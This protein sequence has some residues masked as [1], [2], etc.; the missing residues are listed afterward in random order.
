MQEGNNVDGYGIFKMTHHPEESWRFISFLCSQSSQSYWNKSIG[1]IPTN[2]ESMKEEW[3]QELPHMQLAEKILSSPKL[4]FYEPPMYLP[5][6]RAILDLGNPGI[7]SVMTGEKSVE[8]FLDEWAGAFE[9]SKKNYD[10][11]AEK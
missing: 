1:Q 11:A 6:Y 5:D 3:V 9:Q 10:A 4:K 7:Q 8:E 2:K